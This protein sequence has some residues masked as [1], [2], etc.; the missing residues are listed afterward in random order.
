MCRGFIFLQMA[1]HIDWIREY[2]LSFPHATEGIQWGNDLLFR[3]GNKI[4][5]G[6]PLEPTSP[7][8]MTVKCTP[9]RFAELVE[10]EGIIPAPYMA[11]NKWVAFVEM[12]ALRQPEIKELIRNSYHLVLEKLPKKLQAELGKP[13]S[14]SKAKTRRP[15]AKKH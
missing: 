6:V 10:V 1:S 7:V 4:F 9:E 2:C 5:C 13:V 11:R 12:S 3:I 8:K 14:K 15:K